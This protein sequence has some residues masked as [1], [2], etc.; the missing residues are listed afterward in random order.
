MFTDPTGMPPPQKQP[1][2]EML[3]L[4]QRAKEKDA[5]QQFKGVQLQANM[6]LDQMTKQFEAWKVQIEQQSAERM[7]QIEGMVKAELNDRDNAAKLQKTQVEVEGN[8]RDSVVDAMTQLKLAEKRATENQ[9]EIILQGV[10][11][12]MVEAQKAQQEQMSQYQQHLH[13]LAE[14]ISAPR[15]LTKD[16][17]TGKKTVRTVKNKE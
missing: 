13:K 17:K 9:S 16:P 10:V 8:A 2:I 4:Q 1:P 3:E 7:A 11:E 15:E 5:Q 12:Q 6:Q 14:A